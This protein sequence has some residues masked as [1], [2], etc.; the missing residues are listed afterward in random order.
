MEASQSQSQG[1]DVDYKAKYEELYAACGKANGERK[2]LLTTIAKDI[3]ALLKVICEPDPPGCSGPIP[4]DKLADLLVKVQQANAS[5]QQQL[6]AID[7]K[8]DQL[9]QKICEP[10]PPG[11]SGGS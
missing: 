7:Q 2:K 10:D 11:C 1:A 9:M 8:I 4:G 6:L 3:G 5:K